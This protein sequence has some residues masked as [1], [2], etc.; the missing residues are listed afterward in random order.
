MQ[1]ESSAAFPLLLKEA[2]PEISS[3]TLAKYAYIKIQGETGFSVLL[4]GH[5]W[6]LKALFLSEEKVFQMN[7]WETQVTLKKA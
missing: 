2:G 4:W 3:L 7:G 6:I 1:M 5:R